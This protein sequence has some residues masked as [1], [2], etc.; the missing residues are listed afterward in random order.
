MQAVGERHGKAEQRE[1]RKRQVAQA[2]LPRPQEK[3]QAHPEKGADE[4]DVGQVREDADLPGEPTDEAQ[5][6]GEDA[7][8]PDRDLQA[9]RSRVEATLEEAQHVSG[10]YPNA[11]RL[12]NRRRRGS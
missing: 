7:E 1:E 4:H 10:G 5:L 8:G 3:P 11:D 2:G 12:A 9:R 6:E